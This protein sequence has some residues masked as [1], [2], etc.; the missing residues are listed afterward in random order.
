MRFWVSPFPEEDVNFLT[1]QIGVDRVVFGSIRT[2]PT[3]RAPS[4]RPTT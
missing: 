1:E 4:S 2:G 3:P